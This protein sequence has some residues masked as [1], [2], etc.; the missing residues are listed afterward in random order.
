MKKLAAFPSLDNIER[1]DKQHLHELE[2]KYSKLLNW[3]K[4]QT[5]VT[6]YRVEGEWIPEYSRTPDQTGWWYTTKWS[7]ISSRYK[8]EIQGDHK[9]F[10]LIIPESILE[11]ETAWENALGEVRVPNEELREGRQEITDPTQ[12][13]EPTLENYMNQFAFVREYKRLKT[14]PSA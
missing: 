5:F 7:Q 11:K 2:E 4:D 13:V 1:P 9:I 12:A 3:A 8:H 14:T 10:A 6:V